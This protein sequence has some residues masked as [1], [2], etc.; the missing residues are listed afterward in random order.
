MIF[1]TITYIILRFSLMTTLLVL[2]L[3][4]RAFFEFE[5]GR[6]VSE[7]IMANAL[8]LMSQVHNH[9]SYSESHTIHSASP[10]PA[11]TLSQR[12]LCCYN[13][14]HNQ[15]CARPI[16]PAINFLGARKLS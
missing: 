12:H 10:D 9:A 11:P 16:R 5:K 14:Y 8:G 13:F 4:T 3:T 15:I 1:K 6:L 2:W 7:L